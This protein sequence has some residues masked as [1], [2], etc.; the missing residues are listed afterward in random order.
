MIYRSRSPRAFKGTDSALGDSPAHRRTISVAR[1]SF[2]EICCHL[3]LTLSSPPSPFCPPPEP[4]WAR[5]PPEGSREIPA[6]TDTIPLSESSCGAPGTSPGTPHCPAPRVTR[7]GPHP[8]TALGLLMHPILCRDCLEGR[9]GPKLL[10]PETTTPPR[11]DSDRRPQPRAQTHID[12]TRARSESESGPLP[13]RTVGL[14]QAI[15]C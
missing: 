9:C 4:L 3:P 12:E 1:T 11:S 2:L 14:R 5:S 6:P 8:A 10:P 7:R 13:L 15:S